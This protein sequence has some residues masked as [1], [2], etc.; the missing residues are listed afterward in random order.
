MQ[1]ASE[2]ARAILAAN[3]GMLA[4]AKYL[5]TLINS[6]GALA[7]AA[8]QPSGGALG[9][10]EELLRL[11]T[12]IHELRAAAVEERVEFLVRLEDLKKLVLSRCDS[13]EG[14]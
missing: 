9:E 8:C 4:R 2:N 3:E 1:I 6:V 11:L 13:Q 5:A 14:G 10:K 7:C 12:K